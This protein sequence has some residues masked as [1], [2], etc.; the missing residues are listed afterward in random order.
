[1]GIFALA[2]ILLIGCNDKSEPGSDSGDVRPPDS[3]L[4][5]DGWTIEDGDCNDDDAKVHPDA[6][7][8]CNGQDDNCDGQVDEGLETWTWYADLDGDGYGA[9]EVTECAQPEQSSDVGGDCDDADADINPDATE[10]CDG[11]DNDCDGLTDESDSIDASTWYPDKDADGFGYDAEPFNSCERPDGYIA[12]GGDCLDSNGLVYPGAEELCDELDNDCDGLI[13]EDEAIDALTWYHDGDSDN[14]GDPN[15]TAPGCDAPDGYVET[16]TDCD[17]TDASINPGATEIPYDGEDNDCDENTP[18]DDIDEDGYGIAED[19]DDEDDDSFPGGVE[20]CDDADNDCNGLVDD[21]ALDAEPW[22]V[23]SDGDGYGDS[24]SSIQACSESS[25]YVANS[26]DCDDSN[27]EAYPA[28]APN[29]STTECMSDVDGDDYGDESSSGDVVPGSDCDDRDNTIYPGAYEVDGVK[30]NDCAGDTEEMPVAVADYDSD[31]STLLHCD[32]LY[33]DATGSSDPNA[34]A[35]S[36]EWSL[37]AAPT[38]SLRVSADIIETTDVEPL[39][40]PDIAGIYDFSLLVTDSGDAPSYVDTLSVSIST[41][42]TNTDPVA[43]AGEDVSSSDSVT[44][45]S[46]GYGG[47]VCN[48]CDDLTVTLDGSGSVDVDGDPIDYSWTVISG[49]SYATIADAS[50]ETTSVTLSDIEATYGST[51]TYTVEIQLETTDCPGTNDTDLIT[52]TYE[53]TGE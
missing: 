17:D 50:A 49:S 52:I 14:Y 39:F 7:E 12:D 10:I 37:E 33:L 42:K 13:D 8:T 1:M 2:F 6:P 20:V 30:D 23:D 43:D 34:D 38:G 36:Y 24:R 31:L 26:A 5:G 21:G 48:D 40:Y 45:S 18:D 47:Y 32:P 11:I 51:D 15:D 46:D 53:C 25:G 44:C 4:D 19:C 35:L 16:D 29:D 27:P 28:A 41:R 9:L 22:Y 3:D